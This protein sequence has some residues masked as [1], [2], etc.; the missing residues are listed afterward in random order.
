M[1][2]HFYN[3]TTGILHPDSVHTNIENS[4]RA[5][6]FARANAPLDHLEIAGEYDDLCQRVNV[7]TGAVVDYQPAAPSP[8]HQWDERTK[9]W[10]LS[11]LAQSKAVASVSANARVATLADEERHLV[12]RLVLNPS[13]TAA[14]AR[15]DAIDVEIAALQAVQ[16]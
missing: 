12:R 1:R 2:F 15:L 16:R 3:K 11:A 13:D 8:D 14:H 7:E 4:E 9:R 10:G 5:L 6:K